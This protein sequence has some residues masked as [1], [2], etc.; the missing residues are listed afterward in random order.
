[1]SPQD[2]K[3]AMKKLQHQ[4]IQHVAFDGSCKIWGE[5]KYQN[6]LGDRIIN[7]ECVGHDEFDEQVA[8]AVRKADIKLPAFRTIVWT[9]GYENAQQWG[10]RLGRKTTLF[11]SAEKAGRKDTKYVCFTDEG[12]DAIAT[13]D[14]APTPEPVKIENEGYVVKMPGSTAAQEKQEAVALQSKVDSQP[15]EEKLDEQIEQ[16]EPVATDSQPEAIAPPVA[17]NNKVVAKVP[18]EKPKHE[19]AQVE[20]KAPV[21]APNLPTAT[22][23]NV[24][25]ATVKN[26]DIKYFQNK[27]LVQLGRFSKPLSVDYK[28]LYK[29]TLR[30]AVIGKGKYTTHWVLATYPTDNIE[31]AKRQKALMASID[32]A[33]ENAIVL[34]AS[35]YFTDL[36]Y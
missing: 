32:P 21:G 34:P 8:V 35:E 25:V 9:A 7:L 33:F 11:I 24:E 22:H 2:K 6:I 13:S 30:T 27:Y 14:S 10:E 16:L 4:F 20:N 19:A 17:P 23:A 1:M 18:S 36:D 29:A 5:T 15:I 28:S 31:D 26:A 12:E 3:A